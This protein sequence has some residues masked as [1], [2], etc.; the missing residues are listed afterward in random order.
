MLLWSDGSLSMADLALGNRGGVVALSQVSLTLQPGS[1]LACM[2]PAEQIAQGAG[3][4]ATLALEP[5]WSDLSATE[6]VR[7]SCSVLASAGRALHDNHLL[8]AS[9]EIT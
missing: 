5:E 8:N 6:Q 7:R 1:C 9:T 3:E 4:L 2:Q